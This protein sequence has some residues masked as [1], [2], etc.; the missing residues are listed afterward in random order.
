M[1]SSGRKGTLSEHVGDC[2]RPLWKAR[3]KSLLFNVVLYM[4]NTL[5]LEFKWKDIGISS[6]SGLL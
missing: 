1:T 4:I 3:I 2:G 6:F 5:M